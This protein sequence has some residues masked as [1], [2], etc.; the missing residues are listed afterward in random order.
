M[1]DPAQMTRTEVARAAALCAAA[2]ECLTFRPGAEEYGI[3]IL[4]VQEIGLGSVKN[5]EDERMPIPPDI[6]QL[7]SGADS[8]WADAALQVH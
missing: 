8:E 2:G 1:T 4:K 7:M 6:E 3:D 5:G